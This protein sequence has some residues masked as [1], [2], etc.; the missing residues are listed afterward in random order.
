MLQLMTGRLRLQP[1]SR[2]DAADLQAMAADER[3]S[4][5]SLNIPHPFPGGAAEAWIAEQ[6]AGWENGTHYAFALR[7]KETGAFIGV[8][9]LLVN[10]P[11]AKGELAYAT[12]PAAWGK[13]YA[14]EACREL[15]R[16]GFEQV[17]L[18]RLTANH[19]TSNTASARVLEKLGFREEARLEPE[20]TDGSDSFGL[21]FWGLMR[22]EHLASS[23][24]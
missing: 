9:A 12:V 3:V 14:T 23:E 8:A 15:V 22:D 19:L 24:R 16:F 13:G 17:Q 7:V 11:K 5:H 4:A 10:P 6:Q 1:I 21:L 20:P 18:I 2:Q